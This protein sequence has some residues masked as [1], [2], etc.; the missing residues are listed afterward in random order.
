MNVTSSVAALPARVVPLPGESLVSLVRRTAAAMGYE[1]PHRLR[2]LIVDAGK[3]Q[4]NVN[5]LHPGPILD[6]L[7]V[8]LRQPPEM[9]LSMTVHRLAPTLVFPGEP[10]HRS[11][12]VSRPRRI[13]DRR[14]PLLQETCGRGPWLGLRPATARGGIPGLSGLFEAGHRSVR[15]LGM[16]AVL[17]AGLP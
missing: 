7:A 12:R 2:A 8:L 1:G 6:I 15:T 4:A 3:V 14:S 5:A 11:A 16:V 13:R 9:L 17:A 10:S